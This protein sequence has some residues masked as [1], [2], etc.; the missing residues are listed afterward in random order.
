MKRFMRTMVA[1]VAMI[2]GVQT[3]KADPT[4]PVA[5]TKPAAPKATRL[6]DD[7]LKETLDRMGY[8]YT[9][10]KGDGKVKQPNIYKIKLARDGWNFYLNVSLS[11]DGNSIWLF[12]PLKALPSADKVPAERLEKIFA[13]TN[14][15]QPAFFSLNK[16]RMLYLNVALVNSDMTAIKLRSEIDLMLSD[17]KATQ[18]VWDSSRWTPE[19][20]KTETIKADKKD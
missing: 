4:P 20:S 15:L 1:A 14:D 5:E 17:V 19:T 13:K 10:D 7:Q 6:T 16:N 3:A 12:A 11:M 9:I 18:E 2:V 8:V